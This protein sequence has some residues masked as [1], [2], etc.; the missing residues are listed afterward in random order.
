MTVAVSLGEM[1][2]ALWLSLSPIRSMAALPSAALPEGSPTI[3]FEQASVTRKVSDGTRDWASAARIWSSDG[4]LPS[5]C[6]IS[7]MPREQEWNSPQGPIS[8]RWGMAFTLAHEMGHCFDT[9]GKAP[10]L[11]ETIRRESYADAFGACLSLKMGM[12]PEEIERVRSAREG[13]SGSEGRRGK[14]QAKAI[15][16][17]ISEP[18]CSQAKGSSQDALDAWAAATRVDIAIFGPHNAAWTPERGLAH[19]LAHRPIKPPTP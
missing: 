1:A 9:R 14:M 7:M 19:R 2:L 6:N 4:G 10:G 11:E 12:P 16:K 18:E 8:H 5:V 15:L 3:I 13:I 17:V